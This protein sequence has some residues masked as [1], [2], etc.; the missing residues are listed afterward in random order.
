[1]TRDI[2]QEKY[3]AISAEDVCRYFEVDAQKGL[4]EKNVRKRQKEDG[5]NALPAHPPR[6]FVSAL[7]HQ[8]TGPL[9]AIIAVA[10]GVS[11][12]IGHI[13]DGIFISSIIILN[14]LLGAFQESKAERALDVLKKS[15]AFQ[16]VVLRNQR[17]HAV[18]SRDIVR[19]D[20]VL[21]SPGDRIPADG[22]IIQEEGLLVAE[23]ALSGESYPVQKIAHEIGEE[24]GVTDRKNMVYAGTIVE[25]G[26]GKYVVTH[27]G[28]ETQMGRIARLIGTQSERQ[29]PLQK[30]LAQLAR[31]MTGFVLV[32]VGV[33]VWI[34]LAKGQAFDEVMLAAVALVV[35]T[36]PEG[37]LP[38]VTVVLVLGMRRLADDKA[39]VRRLSAVE[40]MGAIGVIC[41]DK[42]GTLTTGHMRVSHVRVP[43]EIFTEKDTTQRI[44]FPGGGDACMP[45]HMRALMIGFLVNDAIVENPE[46]AME[47]WRV[48]GRPTDRALLMAGLQSGMRQ[49]D[50]LQGKILK[51]QVLFD[52]KRKYATRT[53][54]DGDGQE[55]YILGASEKVMEMCTSLAFYEGSVPMDDVQRTRLRLYMEEMTREGYRLLACA[56]K[57]VRSA[58]K[59]NSG[60]VEFIGFIALKDPARS[61]VQDAIATAQGAGVRPI[62]ITGD[63]RNTA[64]AIL[65]DVGIDVHQE[66]IY[67]GDEIE[68]MDEVS[69]AH[70]V[71]HAQLFARVS[72][73]HK[74][75]IVRALI[76][77]G[78]VVAMVGDGVNDAPALKAA[79]V[80]IAVGSGTDLAK[81]VADVVLMDDSF[82]TIIRAIRQGRL[83]FLNVKRILFF[84][85]VDDLTELVLFF[86]ALLMGVP[87]PL[88][89][90]QILWINLIEDGLPGMALTASRSGK[91]LMKQPPRRL[92]ESLLSRSLM[93]FAG[94]IFG[95]TSLFAIGV[96]FGALKMNMPI[97]T[98]RTILF[99]FMSIDSLLFAYMMHTFNQPLLSRQALSNKYLNGAVVFSLAILLAGVYVPFL[100]NILSTVALSGEVFA[101]IIG[102]ALV[103][104][105]I[106]EYAKRFFVR[107][108]V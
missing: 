107:T 44:C 97:E 54:Q 18:D 63:H 15:L 86:V 53:Y 108:E 92:N 16:A 47:E 76:A 57:I 46:S 45:M 22:R 40:T 75:R 39:L 78:Q 102:V 42:T 7:L 24:A 87:L 9:M 103:E 37:L 106:L 19:G 100:Q 90:A 104:I 12:A 83:V 88:L 5:E 73:E 105:A 101:I 31:W 41:M 56:Q 35:S 26:T 36:I 71:Q 33:F 21:L 59:D 96:F 70:V 61:D 3:H 68:K 10:A 49:N 65:R 95:V 69:I 89:P 34:G 64:A 81:T 48:N 51:A 13:A 29:S 50:I 91:D 80:G 52:S 62:V 74:I 23:A 28:E 98:V 25:D 94:T 4:T 99:V 27:I 55:T 1:M 67:N 66:N 38:A 85:L 6:T 84:L 77:Q 17:R 43:D 82:A 32:A 2:K 58:S 11:F 8:F 72:P 30:S 93:G 60:D 20:I 79:D 14:A